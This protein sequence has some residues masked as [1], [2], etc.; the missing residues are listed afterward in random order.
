MFDHY[1]RHSHSTH[2]TIDVHE[3][4]A[5]TDASIR[6]AEEM[7]QKALAKVLGS[8]RLE[9][10]EF[11]CVVHHMRDPLNLEQLFVIDY[12][13][14]QKS[15]RVNHRHRGIGEG[16]ESIAAGLVKAL[17]EDIALTMLSNALPSGIRR[18]REA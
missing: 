17:S 10:C 12:R 9:G 14:G 11:D 13:V 8:V 7:E 4:R 15:R 16:D 5:P 3:H 6:L 18:L 2:Q 1:H